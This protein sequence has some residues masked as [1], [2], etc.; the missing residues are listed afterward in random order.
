LLESA[1]QKRLQ[2]FLDQTG[3]MP[4]YQSDYRQWHSTETALLSIYNDSLRAADRGELT[5]FCLL[6]LSAALYTVDHELLFKRS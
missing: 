1:V 5:A 6:D 4:I 3:S 2:S